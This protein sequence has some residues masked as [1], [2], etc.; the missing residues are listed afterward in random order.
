MT[1]EHENAAGYPDFNTPSEVGDALADAGFDIVT[2]ATSMPS[3]GGDRNQDTISFWEDEHE[4]ITLLGIHDS[5]SDSGIR[6]LKKKISRSL[7]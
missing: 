6:L 2:Q 4:K 1:T 5:E 7:L 3:T